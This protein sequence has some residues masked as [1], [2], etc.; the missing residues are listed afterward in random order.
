MRTRF[1]GQLMSILSCSLQGDATE[2][3]T[4]WEREV[5]TYEPDSGNILDHEIKVGAVLLRLPE[6]QLKTHLLMRV[7]RMKKWTN[8]RDEVVA[9]SRA[10]AVAQ[11]QPTPVDIGAGGKRKSDK[12]GKGSKGA[13]KRNNQTQQACSRCGNTGRTSA[14][15]PHS[16]RTCRKCG[17][18]GHLVSVCRSS[19]TP[20]PKAKGGQRRWQRCEC[21]QDLLVLW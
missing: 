10:I 1:A 16:D 4:A 7:D 17:K 2:R 6:S 13:G 18:V 15:C 21:C 11:S 9:I 14:N 12:G 20:Q 8:F 5:A 19:G 3:I